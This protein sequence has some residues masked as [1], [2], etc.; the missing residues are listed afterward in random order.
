[1]RASHKRNQM[2]DPTIVIGAGSAVLGIVTGMGLALALK[3]K[4]RI[5]P[6]DEQK[7]LWRHLEELSN[8]RAEFAAKKKALHKSYDAGTVNEA[9]FV[10]KDA[11]Y[12]HRLEDLD[13]RIDLVVKQLSQEF[14]PKEMEDRDKLLR[15]I[16]D[17]SVL[18]RKIRELELEREKLGSEKDSLSVQ[19][20]ESEEEKKSTLAERN[21]M[22]RKAKEL[23]EQSRALETGIQSLTKEKASLQDRLAST[24]SPDQR[25]DNL[26]NENRLL[27]QSLEK[28]KER[29]TALSKEVAVLETLMERHADIVEQREAKTA[30][31]L[32]EMVVPSNAVIREAVK[33]YPTPEEAYNFVRDSITEIRLDIEANFWMTP[34]EVWRLRAAE[35]EDRAIF[36]CSM[37]RAM[38]KEAK[39]VVVELTSRVQRAVVYNEDRLLTLEELHDYNDFIGPEKQ[40]LDKY[41]FDGAHVKKVLYWFN[42]KDYGQGG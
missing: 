42:D 4:K 32:R 5:M 6:P 40:V 22:E 25:L 26:K 18:T 37:L 28:N 34:E 31:Q 33:A 30:K 21:L 7:D 15:D 38:G 41:V 19:L 16:S 36:L 12:T 11:E 13:A 35:D 8:E 9:A 17:L 23:E 29:S 27:R 20:T 24:Q 1:M 3:A 39:V 2:V 14:L 10:G